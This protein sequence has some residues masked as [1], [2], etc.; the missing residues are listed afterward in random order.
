ME[1]IY[2]EVNSI[3]LQHY[4]ID[5]NLLL[6]N[7]GQKARVSLARSF[8]SA[9]R[10]QIFLMDDPFSA[11]DGSTGNLIFES[12]VLKLL[13]DKIRI[14]A[15]NSH[16]H[17][18]KCFDRI[19]V[20]GHGSILA[21]GSPQELAKSHSDLMAV[22]TGLPPSSLLPL[23]EK[24]SLPTFAKTPSSRPTLLGTMQGSHSIS[25]TQSLK[26]QSLASASIVLS[27]RYGKAK[28]G[29][30]AESKD[31]IHNEKVVSGKVKLL[32]YIEYFSAA[33]LG[34]HYVTE[35]EFYQDVNYSVLS[36]DRFSLGLLIGVVLMILFTGAQIARVLVD[37]FIA[38]WSESEQ[39]NNFASHG[40]YI[41]LGCLILLV[42]VRSI[43]LN[44]LAVRSSRN[45]HL[46]LLRSVLSAPIPLFFDTH[47]IGEV[48]NRFAKDM[49]IVDINIPDFL[50]QLL[51]NWLQVMSAFALCVYASPF[52]AI[53][54][55]PLIIVVYRTY[56]YFS[57][58]SR[59]LKRLE[60]RTRSP[61][62]SSL[63]E[64]LNGLDTIRAY[65]DTGR[66]LL[67]NLV[68]MEKNQ[69]LYFHQWMTLSWVTVR[70]EIG[71]TFVTGS[72]ALL[73][74]CL[75]NSV[76][77]I[78]LGLALAYSIQLTA[79]FQRCIQLSVEFS[80][81]MTSTE[82]LF[83]Y[84]KIPQESAKYDLPKGA[85]KEKEDSHGTSL[86]SMGKS[87]DG[88]E[89]NAPSVDAEGIQL[90][91]YE[92]LKQSEKLPDTPGSI[93]SIWPTSGKVTFSNVWMNYRSN[94]SVLKGINFSI[95]SGERVGICGRTG[96]GKV[97]L[98][99]VL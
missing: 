54:L 61:I 50:L 32:T 20:M 56:Q 37:F 1:S 42:Y 65:G 98:L 40:Y 19:I 81:Y 78:G 10:A 47:T 87:V 60:S 66:F 89:E 31:L 90:T 82:R 2:L 57:A 77:A 39:L 38:R 3:N 62:F 75:R 53:V 49:E 68:R 88:D 24:S 91:K 9:H 33:L 76:S 45:I 13:H 95:K 12:G 83:E 67:N 4:Y 58:A 51:I 92:K 52:F 93:D 79:L 23:D 16:L 73:A 99:F 72:I 7:S 44:K 70:L 25:P 41:S 59:D 15:L 74:V 43:Y 85:G 96:A 27:D 29:G 94:P 46:F 55:L 35:K 80:T 8:F 11:V 63:S 6:L 64:S 48:L 34:R 36:W 5:I 22:V 97:T 14:I 71:S 86:D 28:H 17:L 69:R 26:D 84:L 30:K 18:L 21:D